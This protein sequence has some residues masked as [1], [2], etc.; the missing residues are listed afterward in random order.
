MLEE[1][2]WDA[3]L[4]TS[5]SLQKSFSIVIPS[6]SSEWPQIACIYASFIPHFSDEISSNNIS[7]LL[8]VCRLRSHL[9]FRITRL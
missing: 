3:S 8:T 9:G 6:S 5:T 1:G 7:T 2:L 4:V